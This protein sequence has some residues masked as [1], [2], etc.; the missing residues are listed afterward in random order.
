MTKIF[1]TFGWMVASLSPVSKLLKTA[2]T[3]IAHNWTQFNTIQHNCTQLNTI[4]QGQIHHRQPATQI[5]CTRDGLTQ[6][7]DDTHTDNHTHKEGN[8]RHKHT[9]KY[10][11]LEKCS[12]LLQLPVCQHLWIVGHVVAHPHLGEDVGHNMSMSSDANHPFFA[13]SPPSPGLQNTINPTLTDTKEISVWTS[14]SI[15]LSSRSS[16]ASYSLFKWIKI[17]K[18]WGRGIILVLSKHKISF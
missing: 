5:H 16:I 4:T 7:T 8:K 15:G 14:V 11:E 1:F 13:S 10:A 17:K 9:Q 12:H 6:K 3:S 2:V 18:R